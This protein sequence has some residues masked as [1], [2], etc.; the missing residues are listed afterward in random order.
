MPTIPSDSASHQARQRTNALLPGRWNA[1]RELPMVSHAHDNPE[2]ARTYDRVSDPQFEGGQRLVEGLALEPGE[3][4]LDVGCGTGRLAE[5]MATR[6]GPNVVG[7]DPLPERVALARQRAPN[8]RFEVARAEELGAFADGSFDAACLSAVFHWIEDKA[9][10]LAELARVLRTGGRLGITTRAAELQRAGTLAEVLVPL[11]R[12][13]PYR[14]HATRE[15]SA[16]A[17]T[18]TEIVTLLQQAAFELRELHVIQRRRWH[19]H[20]EDA[21]DFYES[22]AFGNLLSVVPEDLRPR[23]RA[24]LAAAFETRRRPAGIPLLDYGVLLV[25]VHR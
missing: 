20:G 9:R 24:D 17:A 13:P 23:I 11:L 7:V 3:R 12:R 8:L 25:A 6:T 10:A 15:A 18:L 21:V 1:V 19:P 4:V 16:C 2:L 5:W 14:D 22:S